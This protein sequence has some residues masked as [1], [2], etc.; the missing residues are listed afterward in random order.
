MRKEW[1]RMIDDLKLDFYRHDINTVKS[2]EGSTTVRD[3]FTECD[4]WRHYD[5]FF[6]LTEEIQKKY[7]NLI[8]QQASGGG[9]RFDFGTLSCWDEHYTS[10]NAVMPHLYQA[11]SG[12]S[13]YLPPEVLVTPNGMTNQAGSPNLDTMLRAIYTL[14]NTPMIFNGIL[15]R[16][17][18]EFTPSMKAKF[19]HNDKIF[20]SFIRPLLSTSKVYHHAPV[21]ETGGVETGPWFAMEFS[22]PDKKKG[23]ATVIRLGGGE[24]EN[25]LLKPRGLDQERTY[26][27][28]FDNTGETVSLDGYRLRQEGISMGVSG[29][30]ASELILFQAR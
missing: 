4:Y 2:G 28:T 21:N 20:K 14:G 30:L 29:E 17:V 7:P 3:G 22:S 16:T 8:L 13:V 12:L 15:P 18:E 11:A 24:P 19:L 9:T 26:E 27:V 1:N 5:A 6:G 23:W 25:Y 10:D